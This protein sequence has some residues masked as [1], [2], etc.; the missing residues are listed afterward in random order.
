[1]SS[2]DI[3]PATLEE[4][5]QAIAEAEEQH[6]AYGALVDAARYAYDEALK[7]QRE[8]RDKLMALRKAKMQAS[9]RLLMLR[10]HR[11]LNYVLSL[12]D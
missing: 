1:M 9:D 3:R 7:C 5:N 8:L 11:T 10:A 2:H 6:L 4:F 12:E